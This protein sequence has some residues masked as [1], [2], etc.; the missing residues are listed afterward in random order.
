MTMVMMVLADPGRGGGGG[1]LPGI[2]FV[3]PRL[4]TLPI[5]K[6]ETNKN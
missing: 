1:V 3:L 5:F 2:L 4:L 6:E